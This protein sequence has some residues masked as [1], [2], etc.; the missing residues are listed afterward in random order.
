M[1]RG[2]Q[3]SWA[4]FKDVD[5]HVD[6]QTSPSPCLRL[7]LHISL[8]RETLA[9]GCSTIFGSILGFLTSCT[10]QH[11]KI[12]RVVLPHVT[13][14]SNCE[15]STN[16]RVSF[17]FR[18]INEPWFVGLTERPLVVARLHPRGGFHHGRRRKWITSPQEVHTWFGYVTVQLYHGWPYLRR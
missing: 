11:L 9:V 10:N 3:S 1:H 15:A 2:V 4:A 16:A 7:Q 14:V 5:S 17:V 13:R 12:G 18:S 6:R 8:P